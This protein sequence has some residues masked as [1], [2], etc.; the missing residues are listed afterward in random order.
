MTKRE[1]LDKLKWDLMYIEK[2]SLMLD[3]KIILMT[4]PVVLRGSDDV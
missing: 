2:H 1:F 3:L 4:V